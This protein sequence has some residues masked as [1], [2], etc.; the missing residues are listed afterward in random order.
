MP[1][2][3]KKPVSRESNGFVREAGKIRQVII[4]LSPPNLIGFRAKGCRKVYHLT[5]N[6]C[7]TL[8]VKAEMAAIKRDK[9]QNKKQK[10][11]KRGNL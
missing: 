2:P 6:T 7:Y 11:I 1:Y 3:L 4:I 10:R 5:A 9:M 8:A